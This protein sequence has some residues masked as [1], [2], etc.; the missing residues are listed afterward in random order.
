MYQEKSTTN[1]RLS[2]PSI[3]ATTTLKITLTLIL[4]RGFVK[5]SRGNVDGDPFTEQGF[6][7]SPVCYSNPAAFSLVKI[8][9]SWLGEREK[10]RGLTRSPDSL[11]VSW[12]L[13]KHTAK[14]TRW[15]DPRVHQ[16]RIDARLPETW[17]LG[18]ACIRDNA[19]RI[20]IYERFS[21]R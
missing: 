3:R 6:T 12:K 21:L 10:E 17:T 7:G 15:T 19:A 18:Q 13:N 8:I 20:N 14:P 9:Q 2:R 11:W 4:P 16:G 1:A 5:R